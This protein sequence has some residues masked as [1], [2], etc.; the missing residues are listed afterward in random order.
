MGPDRDI[1]KNVIG[2]IL[3][4]KCTSFLRYSQVFRLLSDHANLKWSCWKSDSV[5][6]SVTLLPVLK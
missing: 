5:V 4:L 3:I 1:G 6:D 2:V